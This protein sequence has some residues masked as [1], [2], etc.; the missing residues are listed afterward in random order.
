LL[1]SA[2]PL[3][4][5][6]A[7]PAE[8][9]A[10][11]HR[12]ALPDMRPSYE[13][14]PAEALSEADLT[15]YLQAARDLVQ[16]CRSWNALAHHLLYENVSVNDRFASLDAALDPET[17][18]HVRRIRLSTRRLDH[19]AVILRRCRQAVL[20]VQP[21][22]K[23]LPAAVSQHSLINS[24]ALFWAQSAPMQAVRSFELLESMLEATPNLVHL[25]LSTSCSYFEPRETLL[26][27]PLPN[28]TS[29]VLSHVRSFYVC[30]FFDQR[31]QLTH[32]TIDSVHIKQGCVPILPSLLVLTLLS[33]P[34]T[35]VVPFP[36]IL[37][38]FPNLRELEYDVRNSIEYPGFF[39]GTGEETMTS[40]L[41]VRLRASTKG[42]D[43]FAAAH[44][45]LFLKPMFKAVESVVLDGP[46]WDAAW[47]R[48]DWKAYQRLSDELCARGGGIAVDLG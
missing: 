18:R 46:N 29:L 17:A 47:M 31:P 21:G 20:I 3:L 45:R 24:R 32:L 25:S 40:L 14:A 12:L 13:A 44:F 27:P 34:V 39:S 1:P 30:P 26:V 37:E 41:C 10:I 6:P 9:W 33:E 23:N 11:I 16:V 38:R 4:P 7:L 5:L 28:L 48:R 22:F 15:R 2:M 42:L 35:R 8:L 43:R 36:D 19:N